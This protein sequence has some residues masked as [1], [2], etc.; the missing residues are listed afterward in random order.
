M[1]VVAKVSGILLALPLSLLAEPQLPPAAHMQVDFKQHVQPILSQNCYSCHGPKQQQSGLRL[2]LRQNA[3]RGG[4]YGPVIIPGK[5]A[6]SKLI[7]RLVSGDGGMQMPPTGPLA[8]EEIGILRAWI[9][10]GGE[11][12]DVE[13]NEIA[14]PK[15]VDPQLKALIAATRSQ[16]LRLVRKLVTAK[17]LLVRGQDS[18]G[19]TALH[20]AA[21]FGD[22]AMM[23]VL[24]EAGAD[25][26]ARNSRGATPLHWAAADE[27]KIRLLLNRGAAVNTR[28]ETGR[29]A[30][31]LAASQSGRQDVVRLLLEKGADPN[32]ATLA[33][34]TPLMA[35]SAEGELA[36]MQL[37]LA[38]KADPRAASGTGSTALFDAARSRNL[39][40]VRLLLDAGADVNT[41]T[42]RRES[43]LSLAAMQGAESIVKL[44]IDRGAE[45]NGQDERGYSALMYAA[46]CEAAPAEIVRMLQAKGA[47]KSVMGEGETAQS[48]AGK[49]GDNEVAR[50]LGV[51][52]VQRLTGGVVA[53]VNPSREDRSVS[54]AVQ[55]AFI[56]LEKQSPTFVKRG[57]CNSC[58]N[59][60]LPSA[61]LA[62]ARERGIA[63]PKSLV[64][65]SREMR[66]TSPER[67][68][69]LDTFGVNSL[70]YEMFRNAATGQPSDEYTDAVVRFI[71]VMQTPAGFWQTPGNRPP[72]TFDP[73][74]TAAMAINTL[75]IYSPVAQRADTQRRLARAA[76]WLESSHPV[77]TQERAFHLLGLHWTK[78]AAGAIERATRG[79]VETQHAD[80]GWSQLPT[81][82]SD[83]Y[84][85]GEALYS[86]HLAGKMPATDGVYQK[87]V[88]YLLRTQA[89]NGTW[90]VKTRSLPVQPYFDSGFPYGHDQWI[91]AA[92][93][94]WAAMALALTVEPQKISRR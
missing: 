67:V 49:R 46:Y 69:E 28:T 74:I 9:D 44:L 91:S 20:H 42:K 72:L 82:G 80:G 32:L 79:L 85:T 60:Y 47:D 16:D 3:L 22:P 25:V 39:D 83:A 59:Q 27:E 81:M 63:V 29:T 66:E 53:L 11:F 55:K 89:A 61:A 76:A 52:E 77:T 87:G 31:Y 68:M 56:Q 70:G 84:A 64:E 38:K 23:R 93:T 58:H 92:G 88:R 73:Y 35:A 57:G 4:D 71:K 14:P 1:N 12:G 37:L 21:A 45:V 43:V 75:R 24:L 8:A 17:L 86:L 33:G 30:L 13:I 36:T 5:S 34:R 40:A 41:L 19:S 6:E 7:L 62:L 18:G 54:E 26:N 51:S 90:H 2:D 50:L 78:G 10:Q 65:V 15:P 48:L 94:S